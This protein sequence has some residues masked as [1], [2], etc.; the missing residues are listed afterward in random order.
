MLRFQ[1]QLTQLTP[2]RRLSLRL[3]QYGDCSR[4]YSTPASKPSRIQ[5]IKHP[6]TE[7]DDIEL[8]SPHILCT[9]TGN[10]GLDLN[11]GEP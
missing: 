11:Q 1:C 6:L 10:S 5:V 3:S 9:E 4:P 7:L 2:G 8:K